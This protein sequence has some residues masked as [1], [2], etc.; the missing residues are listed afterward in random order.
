MTLRRIT[1]GKFLFHRGFISLLRFAGI[2][3]CAVKLC[4]VGTDHNSGFFLP[5]G[6]SALRVIGKNS[7]QSRVF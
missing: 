5:L 3:R 6:F 4:L 7:R 2:L 1:G